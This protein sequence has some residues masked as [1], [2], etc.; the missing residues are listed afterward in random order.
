MPKICKHFVVFATVCLTTVA[1]Q[2]QNIWN[3]Q[4]PLPADRDPM[5]VCA[6]SPSKAIFVGDD[7]MILETT[8]TGAS[9]M[10]RNLEATELDPYYMVA[11]PSANVGII[12][13]NNGAMRS[14][15]GGAT[16]TL[17]MHPWVMR[18]STEVARLPA[19]EGRPGRCVRDIRT[20][21]SCTA[22]IFGMRT[23]VWRAET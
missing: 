11:F 20:A 4:S 21:R 23:S 6:L 16:S 12:T 19:T 1:A 8:T 14:T 22:W 17:S 10:I 3:R 18:A 5:A 9:W 13:M 2:S 15:D 7:R